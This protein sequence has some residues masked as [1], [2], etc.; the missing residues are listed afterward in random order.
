[1][2]LRINRVRINRARTVVVFLDRTYISTRV[3][4]LD[5]CMN[6]TVEDLSMN[7]LYEWWSI[8]HGAAL[9][10][11]D[12]HR[13]LDQYNT[14]L[15]KA[16]TLHSQRAECHKYTRKYTGR[17]RGTSLYGSEGTQIG[18]KRDAEFETRVWQRRKNWSRQILAGLGGV[19]P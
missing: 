8:H 14:A 5:D 9:N 6:E 3:T 19:T 2:E 11:G 4:P 15:L 1:M 10:S 13:P 7:E 18:R 16:R 12:R 17:A